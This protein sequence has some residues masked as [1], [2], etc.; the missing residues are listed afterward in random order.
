MKLYPTSQSYSLQI[1]NIEYLQTVKNERVERFTINVPSKAID[2][3]MVND[4]M[5]IVSETPGHTELYFNIIDEEA[6]MNVLLRS[7]KQQIE[8]GKELVQYI[9]SRPEMSYHVN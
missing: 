6:H 8:V 7:Q 1:Q 4:V 9:D 2:E 5:S 3:T